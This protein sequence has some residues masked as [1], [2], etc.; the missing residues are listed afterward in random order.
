MNFMKTP[1][2]VKQW[3]PGLL[4]DKYRDSEKVLYLTFD[5]GPV[6]EVT[7]FVLDVLQSY[8]AKAT[9]FC[10]GDNINRYPDVFQQVLAEGHT[11][12][13]HTHHH[14]N[15]WKT[16]TQE[17]L[18]EVD[19]CEDAIERYIDNAPR[20]L[21]RPPYG[22]VTRAQIQKLRSTY[23]IVMWDILSGDFDASFPAT[24][25]LEKSIQH[26]RQG[27]IIIFHD[28]FKAKKNLEFVLPRYIHHFSKLGFQFRAL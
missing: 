14:V 8:A 18:K 25:C 15:G 6:E 24:T 22:R 27:T 20:K 28:S 9:F 23:E 10:V 17:Y 1:W 2:L 4:W 7:P 13:N 21:L 3:Y 12:G 16:S 5:D 26:T 11:V 19:L